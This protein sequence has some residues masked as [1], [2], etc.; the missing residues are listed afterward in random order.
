MN[1]KWRSEQFPLVNIKSVLCR[2]TVIFLPLKEHIVLLESSLSHP[3]SGSPSWR[4]AVNEAD[5]DDS[6]SADPADI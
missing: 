6:P 1:N 3:I 5:L 4:V 2:A